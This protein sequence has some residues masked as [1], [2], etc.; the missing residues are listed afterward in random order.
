MR[1]DGRE[2][3]VLVPVVCVVGVR[4]LFVY[5]RASNPS[6]ALPRAT[7]FRGIVR[8]DY[9]YYLSVPHSVRMSADTRLVGAAWE[10]YG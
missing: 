3:G 2:A 1:D 6:T 9:T 5:V 7:I 10:I 4:T 8:N